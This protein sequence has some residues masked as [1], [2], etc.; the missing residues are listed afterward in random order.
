MTTLVTRKSGRSSTARPSAKGVERASRSPRDLP[1]SR[2]RPAPDITLRSH[3]RVR[4]R[5]C[6]IVVRH[7]TSAL[8]CLPAPP[9]A[10][11]RSFVSYRGRHFATRDA[12]PP[13]RV[14][15]PCRATPP[16]R[17]C[18]LTCGWTCAS[19]YRARNQR[20]SLRDASVRPTES[21]AARSGAGARGPPPPRSRFRPSRSRD[22]RIDWSQPFRS[23]WSSAASCTPPLRQNSLR[24]FPRRAAPRRAV[25]PAEPPRFACGIT[26]I[27]LKNNSLL[28]LD[29]LYRKSL[30]PFIIRNGFA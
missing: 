6:A 14:R 12:T 1:P 21:S 10:N 19:R 2:R 9:F 29:I 4:N 25:E 15:S 7:L 8:A 30:F 18:A 5:P 11:S 16:D 23:V 13:F 20:T 3:N 28:V 24:A 26:S 22:E 17:G 27:S